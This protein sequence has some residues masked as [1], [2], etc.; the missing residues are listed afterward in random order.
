[1]TSRI[2]YSESGN[3]VCARKIALSAARFD[4]GPRVQIVGRQRPVFL[5]LNHELFNDLSRLCLYGGKPRG[6]LILILMACCSQSHSHLTC[7]PFLLLSASNYPEASPAMLSVLI[8]LV[9]VCIIL[10]LL[11]WVITLIPLPPPIARVAQIVIVVIF[12]IYLVYL[13]LP[14]AGGGV[15]HPLLRD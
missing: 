14:L 12:V 10:S 2:T 8:S 6:L 11:Y 3:A 9:I 5:T 13:L 1:M 4:T 7:Q 15:A